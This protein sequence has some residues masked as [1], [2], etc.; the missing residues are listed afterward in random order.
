MQPS[1]SHPSLAPSPLP[2]SRWPLT[3]VATETESTHSAALRIEDANQLDVEVDDEE[4][5]S[6]E[7]E[8]DEED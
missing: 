4:E 6:D 3:E 8:E 2:V 7:E 1:S 5:E